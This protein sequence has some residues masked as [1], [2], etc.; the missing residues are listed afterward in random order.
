MTLYAEAETWAC[1][2]SDET[3]VLKR[4]GKKFKVMT[5][6]D[7]VVIFDIVSENINNLV[8]LLATN[9]EEY[10]VMIINKQTKKYSYVILLANNFLKSNRNG[11]GVS[12]PTS[13]KCVTY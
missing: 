11:M 9:N 1:S 12:L 2:N 5:R 6:K 3:Y 8:L 10:Y 13:G 7:D 4:I